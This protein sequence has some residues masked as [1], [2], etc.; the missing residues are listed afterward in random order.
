MSF[1]ISLILNGIIMFKRNVKNLI[2]VSILLTSISITS[3]SLS[4]HEKPTNLD[5]LVSVINLNTYLTSFQKSKSNSITSDGNCIRDLEFLRE[6]RSKSYYQLSS[7]YNTLASG[8]R[9]YD[10]SQYVMNSDQKDVYAMNL[11]MKK[12][13]L[14]AKISNEVAQEIKN[15]IIN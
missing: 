5:D 10:D 6:V 11:S 1:K 2:S 7:R 14:C 9:F 3:C 13:T 8:S 12:D 4:D 15:T